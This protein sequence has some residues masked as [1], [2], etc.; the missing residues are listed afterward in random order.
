[1]LNDFLSMIQRSWQWRF[2]II[3]SIHNDLRTRFSRSVLG[4]LWM[5]VNPLAMVLMYTLILS[6]VLSAKLEGIES[7]FAYAIY[8]LSGMLGWTLFMDIVQR[9]MGVFVEYANQLKKI[10]FPKVTLPFIVAGS[11]LVSYVSLM[12]VTLI[13]FVLLGH[14]SLLWLWLPFLTLLTLM[15]ALGLGMLLGVIN[16]FVRD[17]G[18]LMNI[19]LQ[20][21]FWFT[22]I[23]YPA[24]V[25][26]DSLQLLQKMNPVYHVV[27]SYHA[28][29]AYNHSPSTL[30]LLFIIV[31]SVLMLVIGAIV[32]KKASS[33]M[34]DVL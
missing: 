1:M 13:A 31:A 2:F 23:V 5:L 22:P 18:P 21:L 29:L 30:S 25:V 33:E 34:M 12:A 28:I 27:D 17:L 3:S 7:R 19:V 15:L 9:S 32:Y 8:L 10:N 11:S 6:A 20:L 26:P 24:H 14:V 16:V 4:G